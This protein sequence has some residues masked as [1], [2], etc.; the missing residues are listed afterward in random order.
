MFVLRRPYIL[1]GLIALYCV[2]FLSY[3]RYYS[4]LPSIPNPLA[5]GDRDATSVQ[6][7]LDN[8]D[9]SS[10]S[11][12]SQTSPS[13]N[14]PALS[15]LNFDTKPLSFYKPESTESPF[16]QERF[17]LQYF[18][19]LMQESGSYCQDGSASSLHC[20][21]VRTMKDTRLDSMCIGQNA[22]LDKKSG[23]LQLDCPLKKPEDLE[24]VPPLGKLREYW[25]ETGPKPMFKKF[26]STGSV[27]SD[28][29]KELLNIPEA[30]KNYTVLVRRE[31]AYPN[32]WHSLM[33]II[34]YAWTMD[35]L[36]LSID[37]ATGKPFFGPEDAERT[38]IVIVDP[39]GDDPYFDLWQMYAQK[40]IRRFHDLKSAEL[41]HENLIVPL[42]GITNPLW[43][44][45]WRPLPCT[46]S[47]L[48]DAFIARTLDYFGTVTEPGWAKRPIRLT[49]ID[50]VSQRRLV[51]QMD[52]LTQ[53][54]E[55]FEETG[56]EIEIQSVDMAAISLA[57]Q[58]EI[59]RN[60]DVL[61]GV[62]GAG[63]TH[64]M[65]QRPGSAVVEIQPRG[66]H[67]QGFR[68]VAKMRGHKFFRTHARKT[69]D[70]DW[71]DKDVM[72][73]EDKFI[74]LVDEAVASMQYKGVLESDVGWKG[75]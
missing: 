73:D 33:M 41:E 27:D 65:W 70:G 36:Q 30:P 54:K 31:D 43:Q 59:A 4:S 38:Q 9:N 32:F 49:W 64:M 57:E 29:K 53:L 20:F 22:F 26:I 56:V 74:R 60:T 67:H 12:H 63:L 69:A 62:H 46:E 42:A 68:N 13:S 40:P 71:H 24:G 2:F 25:F 44:G 35:V 58:V 23:K 47:E 34:S 10:D 16:C 6:D 66:L 61:V 28:R 15:N 8:S 21:H 7:G 14:E 3:Q 39:E 5:S 18:Q 75:S 51:G 55:H 11:P 37:P 17:S 1:V 72:I 50:R 52:L 45:D 19:S 48:L